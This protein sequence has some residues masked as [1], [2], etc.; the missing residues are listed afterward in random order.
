MPILHFDI[1]GKCDRKDD[2]EVEVGMDSQYMLFPSSDEQKWIKPLDK[3]LMTKL[4]KVTKG[5]KV[6]RHKVEWNTDCDLHGYW[7]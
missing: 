5:L 1:H 7:G 6:G 3:A 2:C 4:N